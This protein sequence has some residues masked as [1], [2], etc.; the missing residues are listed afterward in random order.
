[1]VSL[2]FDVLMPL[3]RRTEA[4]LPEICTLVDVVLQAVDECTSGYCY[5]FSVMVPFCPVRV[6]TS[7]LH[8]QYEKGSSGLSLRD[9]SGQCIFQAFCV[10]STGEA[11]FAKVPNG[12]A[13]PNSFR[14]AFYPRYVSPVEGN[15]HIIAVGYL[16]VRAFRPLH[17]PLATLSRDCISHICVS[18]GMFSMLLK[19]LIGIVAPFLLRNALIFAASLRDGVSG[20][21]IRWFCLS[22]PRH[23]GW[24]CPDCIR[25]FLSQ[26]NIGSVREKQNKVFPSH[27]WSPVFQRDVHKDET[28]LDGQA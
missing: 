22:H 18:W 14:T 20:H 19:F 11:Q 21:H 25:R 16:L 5:T 8:W 12:A 4:L 9:K 28:T 27:T 1:M 23:A 10:H 13:P 24:P 17:D 15:S 3:S 6:L 2:W 26:V 7:F